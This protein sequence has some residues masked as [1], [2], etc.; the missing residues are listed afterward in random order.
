M[1]IRELRRS[2]SNHPTRRVI[3]P[4]VKGCVKSGPRSS[5]RTKVER[6][7]LQKRLS[8][9]WIALRQL[10]LA[11]Q[12]LNPRVLYCAARSM[13]FQELLPTRNSGASQNKS[14]RASMRSHRCAGRGRLPLKIS[15]RRVPAILVPINPG[16]DK[17]RFRIIRQL[18]ASDRQFLTCPVETLPCREESSVEVI[19]SQC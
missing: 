8:R 1:N 3:I 17:K 5:I 9:D 2:S 15:H 11:T 13:L 10:D 7:L 14:S 12:H 16:R 18:A 19:A 4:Q 6:H